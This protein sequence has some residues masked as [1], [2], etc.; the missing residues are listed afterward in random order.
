[1]SILSLDSLDD[2]GEGGAVRARGEANPASALYVVCSPCRRVGK[3]LLSRLITEFYVAHKWPVEAFDLADEGPQLIDY[4]P[5]LTTVADIGS[6]RGQMAFFDHLMD[7]RDTAKVIDVSHR[8]FKDF[9]LIA[10]KIRIFEAARRRGIEPIILFLVDRD[11]KSAK[12]YAILQR[13]FASASLLPVRNQ[14]VARG[15]PYYWDTFKN[16]S[17]VHVSLEIPILVSSSTRAVIDQTSFS[18]AAFRE[19]KSIGLPP[20]L[21]GE[22]RGFVKSVFHQ[23]RE[24]EVSLKCGDLWQD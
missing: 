7:D 21:D 4:L 1:M 23:F 19:S 24:I 5:D 10:N 12:A 14:N 3:T 15:I 11:P 18:F 2:V 9:F 16:E 17:H 20:R 6:T 8:A 13:W 22:L